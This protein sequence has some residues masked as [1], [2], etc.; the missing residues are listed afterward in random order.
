MSDERYGLARDALTAAVRVRRTPALALKAAA[1]ALRAG[2]PADVLTLA[3]MS[4]AASDPAR[5]A[6]DYLPL[7]VEALAALGRGADARDVS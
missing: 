6:R 7:H 3:P 1:A 4:E 2:A 5:A